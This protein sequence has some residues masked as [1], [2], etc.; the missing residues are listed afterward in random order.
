[1]PNAAGQYYWVGALAPPR[2]GK[3]LSWITGQSFPE[4][5]VL[6]ESSGLIMHNRMATVP[7]MASGHRE[8]CL[9]CQ[10]TFARLGQSKYPELGSKGLASHFSTLCHHAVRFGVQYCSHSLPPSRRMDDPFDPHR[11]IHCDR[12]SGLLLR[13]TQHRG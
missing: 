3:F 9:S 1:M 4:F 7:G 8:C 12:G 13:Q 6:L 11:W 10:R 2:Y 5:F